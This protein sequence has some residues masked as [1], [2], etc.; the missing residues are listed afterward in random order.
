MYKGTTEKTCIQCGSTFRGG[1]NQTCN[2]CRTIDRHCATC[3]KTYRGRERQCYEC[4]ATDRPCIACGRVF[5]NVTRTC[6]QCLS[7]ERPCKICGKTFRGIKNTC[8]S[9]APVQRECACGSQY[10]GTA[11]TCRPCSATERECAICHQS[12]IDGGHTVCRSCRVTTRQCETCGRD[13]RGDQRECSGCR[14]ALRQCIT[15]GN[16]FRTAGYLECLTCSGRASVYNAARRIRRL[17][18]QVDGPLPRTVYRTIL[19]SG[20]CVYCG[21]PATCLDHVRPLARGG[22]ET[23]SNLVPAC[24]DCNSRKSARL[25]IHWNPERVAHG[26][27]QSS[28]VAAELEREL[29]GVKAPRRREADTS[30]D[31][32]T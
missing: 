2:P 9:C 3:G 12:F 32:G 19:A 16:T 15:C 31:S 30:Y 8:P 27:A 6:P 17:T 26:A 13:F 24:K 28:L 21:E 4:R 18:A 20:P 22:E 25:L 29:S 10:R 11:L 7:T 23:A 5:H 14:T 1:T